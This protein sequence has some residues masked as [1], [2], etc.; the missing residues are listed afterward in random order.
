MD[1]VIQCD[2][3]GLSWAAYLKTQARSAE[4]IAINFSPWRPTLDQCPDGSLLLTFK[5]NG[6]TYSAFPTD[7]KPVPGA[8]SLLKI[9][10]YS[11][12]TLKLADVPRVLM[13]FNAL[14]TEGGTAF[15]G[16]DPEDGE[17]KWFST[18]NT[19]GAA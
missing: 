11:D 8:S 14:C 19:K 7:E 6:K 9:E 13:L 3:R 10:T 15:M 16:Y 18:K 1:C 17:R 4:R 2:E 5:S 12:G